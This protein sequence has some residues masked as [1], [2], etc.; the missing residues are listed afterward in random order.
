MNRELIAQMQRD[1]SRKNAILELYRKLHNEINEAIKNGDRAKADSLQRVIDN[2]FS[3]YLGSNDIIIQEVINGNIKDIRTTNGIYVCL[4]AYDADN[5]LI[6]PLDKRVKYKV[7][8]DVEKSLGSNIKVSKEN[9]SKFEN[10]H[11]VLFAPEGVKPV[12]FFKQLQLQYYK[13]AIEQGDAYAKEAV[14][15]SGKRI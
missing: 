15:S 7:Y 1:L 14:L 13:N 5:Y 10:M 6:S 4:G 2:D 11:T 8:V 9:C 3:D 12:V